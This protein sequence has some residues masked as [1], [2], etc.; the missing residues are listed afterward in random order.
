M[1]NNNP[2]TSIDNKPTNRSEENN[3]A[4]KKVYFEVR[5][6]AR[7]VFKFIKD[8]V[9]IADDTDPQTTMTNIIKGV[10]F[11]GDNI[12][13]LFFAIVIASVGLNV[14]STAVIIGA[15]LVSPLMGPIMGLGLSI[16]INDGELFKKSIKN[17]G[18]MVLIS[19]IASSL[20][21]LLTPLGDAQ[22]ELLARTQPT[23]FD[24][25]IAF[26]GG[27]AGIL[28]SSRKQEKVT[29]VSGVAIATA[30][31]P[32]LCTVGYGIGTGQLMY[33]LG[34][35]YLFFINSFFIALATFLMVRY[36]KFPHKTFLDPEREKKVKRMIMVFAIVVIVPSVF[37]AFDV[38]RESSFNA[39]ARAYVKDIESSVVFDDVQV[40]SQKRTYKRG[41]SSITLSLVGKELTADQKEILSQRLEEFGLED[42][43][44]HIKQAS[45]GSLD[46][47]TQAKMLQQF[48]ENKEEVIAQRDS[49]IVVLN[50]KL[51]EQKEKSAI[52]TEQLAKEV[53]VIYP[54]VLNLSFSKST[55]KVNV[56]T[57]KEETYPAIDVQW[58]TGVSDDVKSEFNSWVKVRLNVMKITIHHNCPAAQQ[59][60]KEVVENIVPST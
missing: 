21:F 57:L 28:A 38:I 8:L 58:A 19:I 56:E 9:N 5:K 45:A 29:V 42:T 22:S 50:K 53:K 31:M 39:S 55:K 10:E 30:L 59:A 20:Y 60:S 6:V 24:V 40:V 23:I 52:K 34:A 51:E 15:M 36:L 32:P 49:T 25:F 18:L 3:A 17:F 13:V 7:I 54:N 27:M 44:L 35:I 16:G 47:D 11:R 46:I 33:S 48:I 26:F 1:E 4:S 41:E 2:N 14:N 43:K 12:W 37:I